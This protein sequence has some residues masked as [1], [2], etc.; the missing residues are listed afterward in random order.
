MPIL[1]DSEEGMSGVEG[2]A[3]ERGNWT[4]LTGGVESRDGSVT[5]RVRGGVGSGLN[6]SRCPA[7]W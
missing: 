1:M 4:L 6:H 2:I 5:V 7:V 3:Y